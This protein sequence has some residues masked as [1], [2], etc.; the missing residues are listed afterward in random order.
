MRETAFLRKKAPY[1]YHAYNVL[2]TVYMQA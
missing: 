2:E 1:F